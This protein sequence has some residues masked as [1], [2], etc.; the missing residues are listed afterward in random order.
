MGQCHLS[1]IC[2]LGSVLGHSVEVLIDGG[3]TY[4]FL[5]ERVAL[6]LGIPIVKSHNFTIM[7]GNGDTLQ[8]SGLCSTVTLDLGGHRFPVDFF[9]LPI[10][11]A[12]MVLGAQWLSTLGPVLMDYKKLT[13]TFAWNGQT[14]TLLGCQP[15]TIEPIHLHQLECY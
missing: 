6:H 11:G 1:I 3:S 14:V 15:I 12:D 5:Q 13:L 2:L 4:N 8:C 10:R 7:I 9:V